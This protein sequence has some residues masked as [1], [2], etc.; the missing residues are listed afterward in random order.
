MIL[1]ITGVLA[2]D[3]GVARPARSGHARAAGLGDDGR[4]PALDHSPMPAGQPEVGL[5]LTVVHAMDGV[6]VVEVAGELDMATVPRLE[7]TVR[8]VLDGRPRVLVIDLLRVG[9]V[10]SSGLA[11][12]LVAKE[13][14]AGRT[15]V[16]VVA[17]G[18]ITL[19]PMQLTGVDREL[20]VYPT[21][22][23][24]LAAE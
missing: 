22:E 16:R 13:Q 2:A 10:G 6:M 20:A 14:A 24:A 1:A 3:P 8:G 11:M 7:E 17:A 9:F 18:R 12:L 19:R 5:A 15:R 21:R 4:V 23:L